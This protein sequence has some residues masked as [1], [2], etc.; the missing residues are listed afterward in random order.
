SSPGVKVVSGDFNADGKTDLALTGAT[1]WDCLP[2]ATSKGDGTFTTTCGAAGMSWGNW[3]AS[4]NVKVVTGDFNADG[5]TDLALT[6]PSGWDC[7]PVATSKGDGTFTT[8][9]GAPKGGSWGFWASSPGVT[10]I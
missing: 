5:K 1:G 9:C 7:L 2:V 3:A 10:V 6:G 4:P 8:T